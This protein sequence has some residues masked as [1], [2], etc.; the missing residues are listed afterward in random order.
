[1][2]HHQCE[3]KSQE[4]PEEM[5][6]IVEMMK[7]V[8]ALRSAADEVLQKFDLTDPQFNVLCILRGGGEEGVTCQ[9]VSDKLIKRD[10]D[11]TRLLDRLE[12]RGLCIRERS[13]QD[14]R[15][16]YARIT[17]AGKELVEA[18]IPPFEE[19]HRRH[20]AFLGEERMSLIREA[21]REI[22]QTVDSFPEVDSFPDERAT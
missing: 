16:V 7:A 8:E 4:R 1:M 15:V 17:P 9:K 13:T 21:M 10:A 11:I 2:R 20:I 22:R 14:R 3:G 12:K 6:L 5:K 18:A 19:M